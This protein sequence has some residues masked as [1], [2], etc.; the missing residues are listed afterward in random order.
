MTC[1]V[2]T[3][4]W[5][6]RP[7]SLVDHPPWANLVPALDHRP[8]LPRPPRSGRGHRSSDIVLRTKN[9]PGKEMGDPWF[10]SFGNTDGTHVSQRERPIYLGWFGGWS[11]W[12]AIFGT[13]F[14]SK[15]RGLI[16]QPKSLGPWMLRT[17][18][19]WWMTKWMVKMFHYKTIND[20]YHNPRIISDP[21]T[22]WA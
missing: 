14:R 10:R 19:N 17:E 21:N 6:G 8:D 15:A 12:W 18:L 22:K 2:H 16:S 4:G 7:E 5:R 9:E 1:F 11:F 3:L 20:Q 13:Y